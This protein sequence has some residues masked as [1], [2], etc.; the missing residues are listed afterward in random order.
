MK[1]RLW[2]DYTEVGETES[3]NKTGPFQHHTEEEPVWSL[4]ISGL[5]LIRYQI[6]T[7][8]SEKPF[9][10]SVSACVPS[11]ASRL[12]VTEPDINTSRPMGPEERIPSWESPQREWRRLPGERAF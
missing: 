10:L 4:D 2:A 11:E 8:G 3:Q 7:V 12:G 6:P 9:N 1:N 5:V